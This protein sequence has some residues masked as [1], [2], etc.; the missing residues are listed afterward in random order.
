ME[1]FTLL[2]LLAAVL[3]KF[4]T[5]MRGGGLDA[6]LSCFPSRS[7]GAGCGAAARSESGGCEKETLEDCG[8]RFPADFAPVRFSGVIL[9]RNAND[10]EPCLKVPGDA[11]L[12]SEQK[13]RGAFCELSWANRSK[14]Q[15]DSEGQEAA[16]HL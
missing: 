11:G 10:R 3:G 16:I 5:N 15:Q 8:G 13:V 4:P 14:P 2:P 7:G 9:N 12:W 6:S 1:T